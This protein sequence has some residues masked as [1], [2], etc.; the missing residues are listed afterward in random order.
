V[1]ADQEKGATTMMWNYRVIKFDDELGESYYIKEVYYD[2]N[3]NPDSYCDASFMG[4]TMDEM[5]VIPER[6][7]RAIDMPI[8]TEEDF[9]K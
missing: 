1:S 6:A 2:A 4:V 8:L 5:Q 9:K 7:Q 3:G